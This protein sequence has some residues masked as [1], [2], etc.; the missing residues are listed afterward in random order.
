MK[1]SCAAFCGVSVFAAV[2]GACGC[3]TG[4]SMVAASAYHKAS[5][6]GTSKAY[7]R[8]PPEDA[9]KRGVNI[10]AGLEGTEI[11]AT[12]ENSTRCTAERG[13]QVLTFRVFESDNGRV[14]LS[15][16][17]GGGHDADANQDLAD[18]LMREICQRLGTVCESGS[19]SL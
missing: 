10:L 19:G 13:D 8:L 2:I 12:D 18:R 11:T 9:F 3:V 17:V 1:R 14:R 6:Y 7:V 5:V 15:L 16:L 4:T